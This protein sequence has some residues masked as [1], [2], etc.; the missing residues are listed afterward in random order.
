MSEQSKVNINQTIREIIKKERKAYKLAGKKEKGEILD[1]LESVTRRPRKSIIRSLTDTSRRRNRRNLKQRKSRIPKKRGRPKKYDGEVV[2]AL[3]FIM[4]A[5]EYP[6]AERL[7]AVIAEA[8]NIFKRDGDYKY[9]TNAESLL[10]NMPLGTLKKYAA[11]IARS[12]GL[13]RGF[14]TTRPA[15][16]DEIPI[17]KESWRD[18]EPGWGQIDTV[19]HSGA[20]LIGTMVYTL[21]YVDHATYWVESIAQLSKS[22][23]A[24]RNSLA[25]LKFRLPFGL[26]GLHPDSGEEFINSVAH[27]F[28]KRNHI[29]YTRS[30]PNHKNDNCFIEQRNNVITRKYIGYERYD[31]EEAMNVMNEL[32]HYINTYNN[33]FQPT[34]K[35]I[36]KKKLANG[37][38]KRVYDTPATPYHRLCAR[39]D[40][41]QEVKDRLTRERESLNPRKLRAK[42]KALTIKL[43][44]VQQQAGYHLGPNS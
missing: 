4:E 40:V 18:K 8:I 43:R 34:V 11:N 28:C 6:C 1:R 21:N 26:K 29:T 13:M 24:T 30:R 12:K 23:E 41:S 3:A 19:V 31:C 15:M 2:A 7:H 38:Y 27:S 32:Y 5:Y 42:I 36:G 39:D 10:R 37:K 9:S 35:L 14:S 33:F 44:K 20:E 16:L 17:L 25:M 22:A